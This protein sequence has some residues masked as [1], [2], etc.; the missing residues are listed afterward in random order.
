MM[1]MVTVMAISERG[2]VYV[3]EWMIY[4]GQPEGMLCCCLLSFYIFVIFC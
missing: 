4:E 2:V 1:A 3:V